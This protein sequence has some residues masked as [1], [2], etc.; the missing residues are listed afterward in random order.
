MKTK[1]H[2]LVTILVVVPL[3]YSCAYFYVVQPEVANHFLSWHG[4][5]LPMDAHY[6]VNSPVLRTLFEPLVRLDRWGFPK[7][8]LWEPSL[9]WQQRYRKSL[10]HIDWEKFHEE[11]KRREAK[12]ETNR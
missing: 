11:A 5:P 9:E 7:R 6:R 10:M 1:R 2:I 12:S 4:I 3:A 8:W